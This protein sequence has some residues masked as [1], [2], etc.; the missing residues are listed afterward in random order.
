MSD[1]VAC[2]CTSCA[3]Q[4]GNGYQLV[5]EQTRSAH[6]EQDN[7]TARINGMLYWSA[8]KEE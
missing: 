7:A 8:K 3:A 5:N 2:Y 1:L 6:M 4:G